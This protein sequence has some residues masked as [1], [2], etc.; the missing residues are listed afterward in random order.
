MLLFNIFIIAIVYLLLFSETYIQNL[1]LLLHR[2]FKFK[3]VQS[4]NLDDLYIWNLFNDEVLFRVFD[5]NKMILLLSKFN[6]IAFP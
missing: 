2:S 6:I 5:N 3:I 4:I 1:I